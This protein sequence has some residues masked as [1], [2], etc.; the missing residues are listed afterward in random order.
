MVFQYQAIPLG[1]L[2]DG[3]AVG[4]P[5]LLREPAIDST[6]NNGPR[7]MSGILDD[8]SRLR[9]SEPTVASSSASCCKSKVGGCQVVERSVRI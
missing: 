7:S 6:L 4:R 1:D 3:A 5:A 9:M 2:V 8:A